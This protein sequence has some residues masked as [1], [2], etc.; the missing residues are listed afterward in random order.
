M[1]KE[2]DSFPVWGTGTAIYVVEENKSVY[3]QYGGIGSTYAKLHGEDLVRELTR[4]KVDKN[5]FWFESRTDVIDYL[6][7]I[8]EGESE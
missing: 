8:K 4:I 7:E 3:G 2:L 6:K 5:Q 1:K